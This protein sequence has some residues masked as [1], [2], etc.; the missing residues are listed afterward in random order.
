MMRAI[1]HPTMVKDSSAWGAQAGVAATLLAAAGFTGGPAELTQTNGWN[2]LGSRW[3][4]SEQYFKPYPVCRWA[5]PAVQ[6]VLTLLTEHSVP[7]E[8]IA[9]VEVTT[10][11]AATRLNTTSPKTTEEAQYSLPFAVAAAVVHGEV[12]TATVL[13]PGSSA[14]VLR[15]ARIVRLVSSPEMTREFPG[16]RRAEVRLVLE[17]GRTFSSGPTT[18]PGDPE[19]PLGEPR[20]TDKFLNNTRVLGPRRSDALKVL[21]LASQPESLHHLLPLMTDPL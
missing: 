16:T 21:L 6:A 11:E 10:F 5:H 2:D 13:H 15:V 9:R 8:L 3:R 19:T 7:A 1:A 14:D 20:L 18:A 4:I 12:S 17:D